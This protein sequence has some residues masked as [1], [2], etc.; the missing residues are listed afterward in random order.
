MRVKQVKRGM[1]HSIDD[2]FDDG[3]CDVYDRCSYLSVNDV[4][5]AVS[6]SLFFV[7]FVPHVCVPF[8]PFQFVDVHDQPLPFHVH[9]SPR[10]HSFAFLSP[11]KTCVSSFPSFQRLQRW[12]QWWDQ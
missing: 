8:P 7:L 4:L 9:V 12:R 11:P 1:Y 3:C 6:L 5:N 10:V 2:C